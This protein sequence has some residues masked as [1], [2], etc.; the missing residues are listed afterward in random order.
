MP[1]VSFS[2]PLIKKK[3]VEKMSVIVTTNITPYV[4]TH[5]RICRMAPYLP[6]ISYISSDVILNGRFLIKSTLFTSGGNRAYANNR[7]S[8]FLAGDGLE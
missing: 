8:L 4:F 1:R 3:Y 5:I 7:D 6:K 2:H